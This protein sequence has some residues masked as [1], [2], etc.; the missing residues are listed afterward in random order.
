MTHHECNALVSEVLN[1]F[2]SRTSTIPY[3]KYGLTIWYNQFDNT[4]VYNLYDSINTMVHI[5]WLYYIDQSSNLRVS[6]CHTKIVSVA[7]FFKAPVRIGDWKLDLEIVTSDDWI[8]CCT[9]LKFCPQWI[10]VL[11][12]FNI[13]CQLYNLIACL[14]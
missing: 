14:F 4:I 9:S 8:F 6:I 3:G 11:R 2:Y 5:I 10:E 13:A 1:K 7:G 12:F